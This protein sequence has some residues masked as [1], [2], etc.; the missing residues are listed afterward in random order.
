M[1]FC[2]SSRFLQ[3]LYFVVMDNSS[4]SIVDGIVSRND[5]AGN[6]DLAP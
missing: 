2:K 5:E 1:I 3:R 6:D 4:E